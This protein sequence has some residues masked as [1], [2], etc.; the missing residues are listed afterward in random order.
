MFSWWAFYSGGFSMI[1][2]K[3]QTAT[4]Y[5]V[6]TAVVIIIALIV[7]G[8]LGGIPGLGSGVS[9]QQKTLE[10]QVE[11]VASSSIAVTDLGTTLTLSNNHESSMR[12]EQVWIDGLP[13]A[14]TD[15][16]FPHQLGVGRNVQITCTNAVDSIIED[17][18]PDVNIIWTDI[19]TESTF[20]TYERQDN[21]KSHE[22][23]W[24][25]DLSGC[26][27]YYVD[28]GC[29]EG[30]VLHTLTGL[31]WQKDLGVDYNTTYDDDNDDYMNWS[32]AIQ[33][34]DDLVLGGHDDWYLPSLN[35]FS[36]IRD[37]TNG[38]CYAD[39]V[40]NCQINSNEIPFI[41]GGVQGGS[42]VFDNY[43]Q[44]SASKQ[45]YWT[46]STTEDVVDNSGGFA[47]FVSLNDRD[48][49]YTQNTDG[50]RAV[51]SRRN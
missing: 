9:D 15:I 24:S 26:L 27:E 14:T 38:D 7:V 23:L 42:T 17:T 19:S 46:S 12:I 34:C 22:C 50:R 51:C 13:C 32:M 5:L 45:R 37:L 20:T 47:W 11:K 30:T 36:F 10:L 35:E 16:T 4:E 48:D 31:C 39:G 40:A 49:Y 18:V 25:D 2:R 43:D 41:V 3:S 29:G 28:D 33:Y 21:M 6:I 44:I 8:V 1:F